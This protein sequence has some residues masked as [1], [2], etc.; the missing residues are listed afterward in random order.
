MSMAAKASR[1][2]FM[3]EMEIELCCTNLKGIHS[4]KRT[5]VL[6]VTKYSEKI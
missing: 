6:R 1:G 2:I 5:A 3:L 4:I